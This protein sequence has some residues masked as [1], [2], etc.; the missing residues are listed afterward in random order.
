MSLDLI[1]IGLIDTAQLFQVKLIS[2]CDDTLEYLEDD[3]TWEGD[4]KVTF[5]YTGGDRS[6]VWEVETTVSQ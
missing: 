6:Y 2:S 5:H 4:I 3:M 1:W